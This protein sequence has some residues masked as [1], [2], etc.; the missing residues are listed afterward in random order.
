[1]SKEVSCSTL[2]ELIALSPEEREALIRE[3]GKI[4]EGNPPPCDTLSAG[5]L[6]Q[7]RDQAEELYLSLE[8]MRA[9]AVAF[10]MEYTDPPHAVQAVATSPEH[11]E[12]LYNALLSMIT[13]NTAQA[14]ELEKKAS[15]LWKACRG[16]A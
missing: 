15:T 16:K 7:L 12:N 1:M 8:R 10:A 3:L 6:S 5:D 14:E 2:A 11:Y 4:T 9:V 13:D